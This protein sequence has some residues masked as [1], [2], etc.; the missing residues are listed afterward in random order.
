MA[1]TAHH[2][3]GPRTG[4]RHYAA[5]AGSQAGAGADMTDRRAQACSSQQVCRVD[6]LLWAWLL[7]QW[8]WQWQWLRLWLHGGAG[9]AGERAPVLGASSKPLS[10]IGLPVRS[11][12]RRSEIVMSVMFGGGYRWMTGQP[13][14]EPPSDRVRCVLI[15]LDKNRRCI[16]KSQSKRPPKRTQRTPHRTR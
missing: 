5:A 3:R 16:G 11:V 13:F 2:Y 9:G 15:F 1:G 10:C 14:G 6:K 12:A 7:W 4:L 8:Q